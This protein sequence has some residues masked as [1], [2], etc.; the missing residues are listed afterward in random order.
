MAWMPYYPI[1]A[2]TSV[3]LAVLVFYALAAHGGRQ[4]S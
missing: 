3:G 1:W 4:S 2:L